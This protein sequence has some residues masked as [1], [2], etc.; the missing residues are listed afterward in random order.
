MRRASWQ[1]CVLAL[2]SFWFP[3][4]AQAESPSQTAIS[5]AVVGE[6]LTHPGVAFG[7]DHPVLRKPVG[8][9]EGSVF[10][11]EHVAGYLH[12]DNHV[13]VRADVAAGVRLTTRSRVLVEASLGA[14]YLHTFLAAPTYG[15]RRDGT[16][17]RR[18]DP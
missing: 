3:M 2:A 13:A 8:G 7:F 4:S 16:L 18:I 17:G 9:G 14:G 12:V 10:V 1:S 6:L 11:A 15:E 5:A